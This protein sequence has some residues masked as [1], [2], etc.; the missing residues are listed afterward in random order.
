MLTSVTC[1]DPRGVPPEIIELDKTV[2]TLEAEIARLKLT[3]IKILAN[4]ALI[5]RLPS[6][7]LGRIFELGTHECNHLPQTL[8]LVSRSWRALA[9]DTPVLWTYVTLD[10]TFGYGASD[11]FL[12]R[13][14]AYLERSQACKI[15]VDIDCQYVD[16]IA[17]LLDIMLL[18]EPHLHRCFSFQAFFMDWEEGI[19]VVR[20]HIRGLGPSLESLSLR[21]DPDDEDDTVPFPLLTAPCPRLQTVVLEQAPLRAVGEKFTDFSRL[22]TLHLVRDQRYVSHP[23]TRT[24]ISLTDLLDRLAALPMLTELC[25]QSANIQFDDEHMLLASPTPT[26]VPSLKYLICNLIDSTTLSLFLESTY[27]PN[28]ERLRVQ[29]CNAPD[30]TGVQ[31]LQHVASIS[32]PRLPSLRYLDLR[33]CN[34][35]GAAL[36]PFVRAL[37]HLP[38]LTALALSSP[39]S[40]CIG[41][42]LFDVLTLGQTSTEKIAPNLQALCLQNCRDVT[43]H[44]LARLV[45]SRLGSNHTATIEYLKL[46]QCY[47]L[48]LTALKQLAAL[49]PVVRV[50]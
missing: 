12:R 25:I 43:G 39:P 7:I 13:A 32:P 44:E 3:R 37:R 24:N 36:F 35:E 29:M 18:L 47:T 31:W 9:L 15:L 22:T 27:F 1:S 10:Q 6:E 41:T 34:V 46:A 14:E 50:V 4:Q 38:E 11:R 33:A 5:W 28:L 23:S 30:D 45:R 21:I 17:D 48:D 42:K 40:G 26:T 16:S 2:A 8:S 20:D 19:T 49:V